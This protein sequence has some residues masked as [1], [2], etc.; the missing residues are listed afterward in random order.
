MDENT[1][2]D[3]VTNHSLYNDEPAKNHTIGNCK[4]LDDYGK[5][6]V[7][8]SNKILII[9]PWVIIIFGTISNILSIIILTRKKLR[10]SSTFF[11]LACLSLIDMLVLYTFCINFIS[12]YHLEIDLQSKHVVL[13]KLFSF[14]IYYLPQYSAW[15]CA[16]VSIKF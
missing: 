6:I 13:C 3:Y 11:Y 14:C 4:E 8:V 10:K 1:S 9:Y 15:T 16:A 2:T 7:N 12:Y 5:Y